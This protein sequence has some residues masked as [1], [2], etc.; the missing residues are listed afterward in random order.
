M[1]AVIVAGLALWQSAS[2][3]P[4]PTPFRK[5]RL[6]LA[7]KSAVDSR[8]LAISPNG[9]MVAYIQDRQLWIHRLDELEPREISGTAEATQPFWSPN[10]D[11]VGYFDQP[12]R[13]LKRVAVQGGAPITIGDLPADFLNG[14]AWGSDGTIVFA[15]EAGLFEV[16]AQGGEPQLLLETDGTNNQDWASPLF[17]ENGQLICVSFWDGN[18][19][20]THVSEGTR[21]TLFEVSQGRVHSLSY[22]PT[23]HLLYQ[24]SQSYLLGGGIWAV[25]FDL[26]TLEATGDPFLVEQEGA[27]P[28]VSADG[29]LSY[30]DRSSGMGLRQLVWVDRDGQ[31]LGPI[32]QSQ[33]RMND[34]ALSRDGTRVGVSAFEDGNADIWIHDVERGTKTRLTTHPAFDFE[35]T[36]SPTGDEVAFASPR[37]GDTNIFIKAADGSGQI[38]SL[39]TGEGSSEGVPHW[40]PD[41]KYIAYFVNG[42]GRNFDIGYVSLA[43]NAT[44]LFLFETPFHENEPA[45]SPDG[46]HIAYTSDESGRYE[47]YVNPFPEGDGR[48][49]VSVNGGMHPRWNGRGA[50]YK[51]VVPSSVKQPQ[52]W[53]YTLKRPPNN[54]TKPDFDDALWK[55]GPGGFGREGTRGLKFGTPWRSARRSR[56]HSWA[57]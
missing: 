39:A 57:T 48:L 37:N 55:S 49:V 1:A 11:F 16:S 45:I 6:P 51:D 21:Q 19:Q 32:G 10:S 29:T 4:T 15:S 41:G 9:K 31:V 2:P 43:D 23:G 7:G 54:W 46:R 12:A 3:T 40:S 13:K 26:E 50:T 56:H 22:S 44:P 33:H 18:S 24:K 27:G 52:V 42:S 36:F 34:L 25:P 35:P 53:K 30:V 38:R 28:S 17:L 20:I 8:D 47:V 14:V 5:F